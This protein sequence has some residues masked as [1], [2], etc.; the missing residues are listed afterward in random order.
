MSVV[1]NEFEVGDVVQVVSE[2][3]EK[4]PFGWVDTMSPLCG[5]TVEISNKW[6]NEGYRTY[7]YKL[8]EDKFGHSWCGNCLTTIEPD[9][10]AATDDEILSLFGT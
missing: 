5:Q 7:V 10:D 8:K 1:C 9:F 6:W 3:Y 4:C 2:P